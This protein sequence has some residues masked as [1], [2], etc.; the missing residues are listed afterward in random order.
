M[1]DAGNSMNFFNQLNCIEK[2]DFQ[3]T[4]QL[5]HLAFQF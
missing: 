5:V 4:L 1:K 2:I 3:F